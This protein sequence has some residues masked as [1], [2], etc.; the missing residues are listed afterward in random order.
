[1]KVTSGKAIPVRTLKCERP[2]MPKAIPI[3]NALILSCF[4]YT[5]YPRRKITIHKIRLMPSTRSGIAVIVW[6]SGYKIYFNSYITT[7]F[8]HPWYG[9]GMVRSQPA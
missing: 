5:R 3:K 9:T 4:R 8:L 7:L 6:G 1:M 2:N